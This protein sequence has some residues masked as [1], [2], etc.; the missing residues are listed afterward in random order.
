MRRITVSAWL[1]VAV[2]CIF[3]VPLMVAQSPEPKQP[4]PASANVSGAELYATYCG[5]C[6]G[7]DGKGPGPLATTRGMSVPDLQLLARRNQGVFPLSRI[8]KLLSGT[9]RSPVIH[10]GI[11]MP[12]WGPA[13]SQSR[14]GREL[15]AHALVRYLESLQK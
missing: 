13:L 14:A 8:E 11:E 4:P 12:V 1:A 3:P 9:S 2:A 7:T 10:G 6:H 5:G 15:R